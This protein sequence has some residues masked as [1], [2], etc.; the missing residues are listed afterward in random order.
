MTRATEGWWWLIILWRAGR[1][2]SWDCRALDVVEVRKFGGIGRF[3]W[4]FGDG[5]VWDWRCAGE[6]VGVQPS[7]A[8][9]L[10]C[11]QSWQC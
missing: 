8:E 9:R 1:L 6:A 5:E 7:Q 11:C 2:V 4:L 3:W 10:T